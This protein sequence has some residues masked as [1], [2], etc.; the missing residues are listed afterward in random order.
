MDIFILMDNSKV[1]TS[2]SSQA[3]YVVRLGLERLIPH[4]P[5]SPDCN[6]IENIIALLKRKIKERRIIFQNTEQLWQTIQE[7]WNNLENLDLCKELAM[8]MRSRYQNVCD[9]QGGATRY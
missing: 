9:N 5:N 7:T 6:P 3:Y 1:H 8:S 2:Y 4:P